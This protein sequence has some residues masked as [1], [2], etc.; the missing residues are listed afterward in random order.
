MSIAEKVAPI[1]KI[2]EQYGR[3]EARRNAGFGLWGKRFSRL[4]I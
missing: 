3:C 2:H 4:M 1:P